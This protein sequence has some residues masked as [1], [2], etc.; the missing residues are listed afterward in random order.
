MEKIV[1]VLSLIWEV[2]QL[3]LQIIGTYFESIYYLVMGHEKKS[4]Q[5]SLVAITGS[6]HGL[7]KEMALIFSSLGAKVALIDVNQENNE[8]VASEIRGGGGTCFPFKCDIRDESQVLKTMA[9]IKQEAGS[10]ID[11]LINNAGITNC[12]PINTMTSDQIK[13]TFEVNVLPQFWTIRAVLP[14]M[15][16]RGSG[17]IVAIASIAGLLGTAN[18]TD[19]CASKFAVIGLMTAL[20]KEIG[21]KNPGIHLTTVCPLSIATGMFKAPKTRF[22]AVFPICETRFVAEEAVSAI[23]RNRT[24]VTVPKSAI[25]FHKIGNIIPLKANQ[26]LQ[27]FFEYGVEP[28][29]NAKED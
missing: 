19:Y 6:G 21:D 12:L 4:V 14:S 2:L 16:K 29:I 3:I 20:E 10:D 9:R 26:I 5:N 23:L 18:L 7:G 25:L 24:L 1:G 13:R 11:I 28:H 8:K 22:E 27:N 15:I 17:H